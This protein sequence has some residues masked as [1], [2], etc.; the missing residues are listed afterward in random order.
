MEDGA[1]FVQI[2]LAMMNTKNRMEDGTLIVLKGHLVLEELLRTKVCAAVQN[3]RFLTR[4]NLSF[5]QLLCIARSIFPDDARTRLP[6]DDHGTDLWDVIEAW[7]Q[8]RNQLAHRLEPTNTLDIIRKIL[9]FSPDCPHPLE[10]EETQAGLSLTIGM[11]IGALG[12][13]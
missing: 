6:Q 7:N 2:K 12:R 5:F 1:E 13:L 3:P 10:H 4:A 11:L 8:L 9:F